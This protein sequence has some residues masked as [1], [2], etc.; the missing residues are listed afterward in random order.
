LICEALSRWLPEQGAEPIPVAAG[1]PWEKGF[2]ESFHSRFRDEFL[3]ADVFESVPDARARG[4]W[5]RRED[6]TV[7]PQSALR[8]KTPKEFSDEW[9]RGLH[10]QP[11]K[12]T[13]NVS[14]S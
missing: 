14:Y 13:E 1:S 12:A 10:G 4:N 6:N 9:D 3:E 8:Y 11:P 5:F 7:R 2:I